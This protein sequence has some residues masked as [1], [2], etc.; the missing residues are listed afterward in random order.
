MGMLKTGIVN[1]KAKITKVESDEELMKFA[2]KS[3]EQQSI[4]S[5]GKKDD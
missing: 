1:K 4:K 5:K 3:D 2:K